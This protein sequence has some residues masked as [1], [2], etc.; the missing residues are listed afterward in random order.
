MALWEGFTTRCILPADQ[1]LFTKDS[2]E[3][4]LQNVPSVHLLG[5][6]SSR[7]DPGL[8]SPPFN[9][10]AAVFVSA[11]ESPARRCPVLSV[12]GPYLLIPA[13]ISSPYATLCHN[14][15][16]HAGSGRR[17]KR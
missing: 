11:L 2:P 4:S 6:A 12:S 16:I 15:I 17:W 9:P 13:A 5:P 7:P 3:F 14:A 10:P 8:E 1:G